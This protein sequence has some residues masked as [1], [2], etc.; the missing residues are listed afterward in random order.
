MAITEDIDV[1][2]SYSSKNKTVADSIVSDFEANGIK[3]WYAPRDIMPGEEWV[4]AITE[5]LQKTKVLVLVYTDES[6][7]SRQVMN[8]VAVAFNAGKTIVPFRLTETKMSSEFEYYLTRVHWLDAITKSLSENITKLRKYVEIILT[9]VENTDYESDIPLRK[10]EKKKKKAKSFIIPIVLGG[11]AAVVLL[12]ALILLPLYF[13]FFG[14]KNKAMKDGIEA[15]NSEYHG[16]KDN[17]SA[18]EYFEKAAKG[19]VVDAYY[20]LGM[21]DERKYDYEAARKK[22]E[23]GVEK[24]SNLAKIELGYLYEKG[25]GVSADV[26]LAKN[27][28]DEALKDGCIEANYFEGEFYLCGYLGEDIDAQKALDYFEKCSESEVSKISADAYTAIGNIYQNGYDEI[29]CDETKAMDNYKKAMDVFPYYQG[30][31]NEYIAEAYLISDDEINSGINY[32]KALEFYEI[33]AAEGDLCSTMRAGYCL[34]FGRGCETDGEKAIEYYRRAADKGIFEAMYMMGNLYET[35]SGN[36]EQDY[37]KAFKWY[38]TAADKGFAKAMNRIGDLYVTQNLGD[39]ENVEECN[40]LA[41]EWYD[42]ALSGGYVYAYSSIGN[43]IENGYNGEA[44]FEGA[45]DYYKKSADYGDPR[46]MAYIGRMYSWGYISSDDNLAE[47]WKWYKKAALEGDTDAMLYLGMK[48]EEINE[49]DEAKKWYL[50]ASIGNNAVAM[51]YIAELYYYAKIIP[52]PDY[53]IAFGWY[54]KATE[55]GDSYSAQKIGNMYY[56]GTVVE[57][58]YTKARINLEKA[59]LN[60]QADAITYSNLGTIYHKGLGVDKDLDKAVQ[61]LTKASSWGTGAACE[62]LGNMYFEGEGVFRDFNEALNYLQTAAENGSVSGE[63]HKKIGDIY[64]YGYTGYQDDEKAKNC[65]L[66]AVRKG[67]EDADLFSNLGMCYYSDG[68]H[69][70]SAE[71]FKKAAELNNDPMDMFNAGIEYY[72]SGEYKESLKWFAKASDNGYIGAEDPRGYIRD[73]INGDHLT[74]AEAAEW[75]KYLN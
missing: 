59:V 12:L 5:A 42:L 18:T 53:E 49:Y 7:D 65:Y 61:Y 40:N 26:K 3:C 50:K 29:E 34:Q 2:V 48:M 1:F 45:F 74:E 52:N 15:F 47:A 20:Y 32:K 14:S 33:A 30:I 66:E 21:L 23:K 4:T 55:F 10:E 46:A 71:Y 39:K 70:L 16:E 8:E 31:A 68:D 11:A 69:K 22:Y 60:G 62:E 63:T 57:K 56:D 38:K 25:L 9:G 51:R 19:G 73:I 41:R 35:G 75:N 54:E 64:F 27:Y 28:Y 24:G 37:D 36:V 72:N 67:I 13:I 6:N 58:D 43:M 17:A 44:D